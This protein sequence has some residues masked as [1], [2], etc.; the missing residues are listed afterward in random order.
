MKLSSISFFLLFSQLS[1]LHGCHEDEITAL[2]SFKSLLT[3]PSGRL[4]SWKGENCCSWHGIR[5]SNSSHVISINLRNPNPDVFARGINSELKLLY[6]SKFTAINGTI[7]PSIF[8]L[9]HF[10][11]LDLSYNN[12]HYSTIPHQ[13][14]NLKSL[15]Y[16]NLSNS[17]F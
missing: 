2:L 17:M 5:C 6:P 1:L 10:K 7:S 13:F 9:V 11:Y 16:L 14:A 4:S 15:V 12:F 8:T 3:D